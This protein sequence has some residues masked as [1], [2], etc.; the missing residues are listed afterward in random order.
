ME[1]SVKIHSKSIAVE[2]KAAD[3][4]RERSNLR[5]GTQ[6]CYPQMKSSRKA[7]V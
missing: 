4:R 7:P 6:Q 2:T 5:Y 1:N 3:Q